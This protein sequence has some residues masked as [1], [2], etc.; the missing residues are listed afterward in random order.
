M[1]TQD[2]EIPVPGSRQLSHMSDGK[3][4]KLAWA[5]QRPRTSE[6]ICTEPRG[7]Q[8]TAPTPSHGLSAPH[9][10]VL[11]STPYNLDPLII[12]SEISKFREAACFC[13]SKVNIR[14]NS[15]ILKHS[16]A[17]EMLLLFRSCSPD[18]SSNTAVCYRPRQMSH[19]LVLPRR[20][21]PYHE[22]RNMSQYLS[23]CCDTRVQPCC[24]RVNIGKDKQN[25][26]SKA[27]GWK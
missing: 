27:Y 22:L 8:R 19:Y 20:S 16:S 7:Y 23:N 15:I 13:W 10:P 1:E 5:V 6:V 9:T 21:R 12:S 3:H 4:C 25:I 17:A 26:I 24:L 11:K 18:V 14:Q 2:G